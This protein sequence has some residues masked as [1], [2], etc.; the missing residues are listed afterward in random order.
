LPPTTPPACERAGCYPVHLF[1]LGVCLKF[2]TRKDG[3]KLDEFLFDLNLEP[4]EKTNLLA[5][6]KADADRLKRLLANWETEVQPR[7]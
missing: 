6:R 5:D 7:R 2:V 3:D 4:Q 1:L